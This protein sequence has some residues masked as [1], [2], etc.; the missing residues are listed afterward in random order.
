MQPGTHQIVI[1]T[2]PGPTIRLQPQEQATLAVRY[3]DPEGVPVSDAQI[4]FALQGETGGATLAG[5]HALTDASGT[6]E[7]GLTAGAESVIFNV[8]VTAQN[9]LPVHFEVAVSVTG[10]VNIEVLSAYD[11]T[12]SATAFE[13]V[14]AE[15]HYGDLCADLSP[16]GQNQPDRARTTSD[17]FGEMLLF[18]NLPADLDYAITLRGQSSEG[19]HLAWGCANVASLQLVP[20]ASVQLGLTARDLHPDASGEFQ[21]N[22]ALELTPDQAESIVDALGPLT[23]LGQC[24][25]DPLQRL[26]DCIV[27]VSS[28]DG[29]LDCVPEST[30]AFATEMDHVRG[31]LDTDD[32]R[33]S[34]TAGSN[35]S[36]EALIREAADATGLGYFSALGSLAGVQPA[37]VQHLQLHS[38]MTLVHDPQQSRYFVWHLLDGLALPDLAPGVWTQLSQLGGLVLEV[39]SLE[40]SYAIGEPTLLSVP[41]HQMTLHPRWAALAAV[42]QHYLAPAGLPPNLPDLMQT[43]LQ[44]IEHPGGGTPLSGCDA[45]DAYICDAVGGATTCPVD[46]CARGLTLLIDLA[47]QHWA[48]LPAAAQLGATFA[49]E[50]PLVDNDGDLQVDQLGSHEQPLSWQLE[51]NLTNT[52]LPPQ[53]AT[54]TATRIA[55]VPQ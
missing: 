34:E 29:A 7:M 38:R 36:L 46:A 9:A 52:W 37:M 5:F 18:E 55:P 42:G 15:L 49:A 23:D 43:V 20:G 10:F 45:V 41:S 40:G 32:C 26:L 33:L 22:T 31:Q 17:G 53:T 39:S 21:V 13:T 1:L 50:I 2:P 14:T 47:E 28:P 48:E 6:A 27:D 12:R 51:L 4:S 30:D 44:T 19:H 16:V 35:P 24:P 54:F 11:G 3:L 25:L 8:E